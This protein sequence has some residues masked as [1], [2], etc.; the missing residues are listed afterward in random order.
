M[1]KISALLVLLSMSTS[2]YAVSNLD[3]MVGYHFSSHVNSKSIS[4]KQE[5]AEASTQNIA[6]EDVSSA[7]DDKA[8][9]DDYGLNTAFLENDKKSLSDITKVGIVE[10]KEFKECLKIK[11][12]GNGTWETY[13]QP[14]EKPE[15]CSEDNWHKLASKAILN[16]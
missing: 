8:D 12:F 15:K 5:T 1:K 11:Q 2:L 16:C 7:N 9:F 3:D 13:C 4:Q 6:S 14:I 10:N